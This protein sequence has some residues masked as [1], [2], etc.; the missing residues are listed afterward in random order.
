MCYIKWFSFFDFNLS[1]SLYFAFCFV[2]LTGLI[3]PFCP[4]FVSV[5]GPGR[6]LSLPTDL[7]TDLGTVGRTRA[8]LF[9]YLCLRCINFLC[10]HPVENDTMKPLVFALYSSYLMHFYSFTL[11][12]SEFMTW[13]KNFCVWPFIIIIIMLLIVHFA[14]VYK[15]GLFSILILKLRKG[16]TLKSCS[17]ATGSSFTS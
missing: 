6:K 4:I 15:G 9:A 7:K 11:F 13:H 10:F 14:S 5:K 8:D 2:F 1:W 17:F 16:I 12:S 3:A